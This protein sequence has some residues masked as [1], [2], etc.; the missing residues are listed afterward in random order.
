MLE[1]LDY[2]IVV[3][4]DYSLS[5]LGIV[6]VFI[7]L[8]LTK[9]ILLIIQKYTKKRVVHLG[10]DEGRFHS[11]YM[12]IS[13]FL[14]T[15]CILLCLNLLGVKIGVIL[16]GSAALL[17]GI[18]FGL[19][20]IFSDFVAGFVILFE[21]TV[22][23]DDIVDVDGII[24]RVKKITLRQTSIETQNDYLIHVPNHKFTGENV[25][26]WSHGRVESRFSVNVSVAYGSDTK[27]VNQLLMN[28]VLNH[29]SIMKTPSP[30]V[31]FNDFGDSS[32]NFQ[33]FFWSK[34]IFGI[35]HIKSEIRYGIDEEFRKGKIQIPFPQRDVHI[36]NK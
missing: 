26:N 19:Q 36:F 9:I 12:I 35:D 4:S 6:G 1:F 14:W 27:L 25:I 10:I 20:N 31:R 18:G 2:K 8:V 16:A 3:V 13:Y 28:C 34:D 24:G 21:G 32:L 5:V 15:L 23:I 22:E 11:L 29:Q 33:I 17:V 30:F 7:T